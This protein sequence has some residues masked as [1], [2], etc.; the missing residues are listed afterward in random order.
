MKLLFDTNNFMINELLY[1][2]NDVL[3]NIGFSSKRINFDEFDN[4]SI[5]NE[6]DL[7]FRYINGSLICVSYPRGLVNFH[8]KNKW[9]MDC[10]DNYFIMKENLIPNIYHNL[11]KQF[12]INRT[13]GDSCYAVT[14]LLESLLISEKEKDFIVHCNFKKDNTKFNIKDGDNSFNFWGSELQKNVSLKE[15]MKLNNIE[16]INFT[17]NIFSNEYIDN[18]TEINTNKIKEILLF[19]N[20]KIFE[21]IDTIIQPFIN[22]HRLPIKIIYHYI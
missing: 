14:V 17:F 18:K 3:V 22:R 9:K 11:P 2:F 15:I 16:I 1:S 8:K 19:F 7:A 4:E 21:W 10:L 20:E 12:K 5:V 6:D 13:N